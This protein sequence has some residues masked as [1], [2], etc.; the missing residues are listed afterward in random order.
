MVR[1]AV[2]LPIPQSVDREAAEQALQRFGYM[3]QETYETGQRNAIEQEDLN[4]RQDLLSPLLDYGSAYMGTATPVAR[5][6]TLPFSNQV[7]PMSGCELTAGGRIR[8]LDRGLWDIRCQVWVNEV[9][10]PGLTGVA[11][12]EVRV[13]RPD[14]TIYS[15]QAQTN[16]TQRPYS[17]TAVASVVVPEPGYL[18]EA[19]LSFIASFR[20]LRG[21]A[22]FNRLTVQHISRDVTTGDTGQ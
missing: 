4:A 5:P 12:W 1:R 17:Q 18:V 13:L 6:M 19:Y 22:N 8:L 2:E 20:S 3:V 7:G 14:M 11:N 15:V 9:P 10:A 21:G 16:E